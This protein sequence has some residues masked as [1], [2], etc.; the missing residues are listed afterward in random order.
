MTSFHKLKA[1]ES[2]ILHRIEDFFISSQYTVQF[3]Y[4]QNV[5]LTR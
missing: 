3:L 5:T 2:F 4:I 1:I